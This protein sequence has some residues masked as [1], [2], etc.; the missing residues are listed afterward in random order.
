MIEK[1]DGSLNHSGIG[2]SGNEG[3]GS[4]DVLETGLAELHHWEGQ[5]AGA[6]R[7]PESVGAVEDDWP[8]AI[9]RP[10]CSCHAPSVLPPAPSSCP[11]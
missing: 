3:K 11:K 7:E 9:C 5:R 8:C 4:R 1:G 6:G 2:G 10:P